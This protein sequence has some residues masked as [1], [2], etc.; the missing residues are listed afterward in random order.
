MAIQHDQVEEQQA[1]LERMIDEFRAAQQRRVEKQE[2]ARSNRDGR[3]HP[4]PPTQDIPP[5]QAN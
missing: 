1:R 4:Q 3:R 2:I 5:A